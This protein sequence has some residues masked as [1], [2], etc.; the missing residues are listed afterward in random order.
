MAQLHQ[1]EAELTKY[2][3]ICDEFQKARSRLDAQTLS[4]AEKDKKIAMLIG[5]LNWEKRSKESVVADTIS[6]TT[7]KRLNDQLEE[8]KRVI[9]LRDNEI[10]R[11]HNQNKMQIFMTKSNL[12][13][14]QTALKEKYDQLREQN[15]T[16]KST[17]EELVKRVKAKELT[18]NLL[19]AENEE[20]CNRETQLNTQVNALKQTIESC[21]IGNKNS[22]V[23][24]PKL[25]AKL[26]DYEAQAQQFQNHQQQ[27]Q[28]QTSSEE[29]QLF[30]INEES[31][32]SE[33]K[34]FDDETTTVSNDSSMGMG[35]P[36]Y[37]DDDDSTFVVMKSLVEEV[38]DGIRSWCY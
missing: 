38:T 25:L 33:Q 5:Q 35:D 4:L 23:N 21:D 8:N 7:I 26:A 18:I 24:V 3:V 28:Q 34:K 14:E 10:A 22:D 20:Y 30:T 37:D 29:R 1:K 16:Y 17:I 11:L 19:K 12:D 9:K 13:E 32:S 6:D 31:A 27:Q 36:I 2:K 15:S